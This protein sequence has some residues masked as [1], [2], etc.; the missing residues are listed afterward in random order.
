[1]P[2]KFIR[3]F[4]TAFLSIITCYGGLLAQNIA[5]FEENKGQWPAQ[6]QFR[7]D[8][9]GGALFLEKSGMTWHLVDQ[10]ADGHH[11]HA[12]ESMKGHVLRMHLEGAAQ[13]PAMLA[14]ENLDGYSNYFKGKNRRNW[15]GNIAAFGNITQQDVYPGIDWKIYSNKRG[16]KYDFIVKPGADPAQIRIH[17]AGAEKIELRS[18]ALIIH[19]SLGEITE[20]APIA[21]QIIDGIKKPITCRFKIDKGEIILQTGKYNPGE[22]L[23][24]DPQLVFGSFSGSAADNWGFTATYDHAGNTYSAGIVFGIGYPTITGAYQQNFAGGHGSRPVD[25]GII[26]Y[27][28]AGKRLYTTYLGGSGNELPQSLVVS[29]NNELFLFGTT[30]S[31]DFPTTSTAYNRAFAGGE[32]VSILNNGIRFENG[33]DMFICRLSETGNSLLA[34]TLIGGSKNDGLN[35][36][37]QLKYNYAD[38]GRGAIIIDNLN[39]VYIGCSTSSLDFPVPGNAFQPAYGGGMQD[40]VVIK[41]DMNLTR[42]FWGSYL[43]GSGAD[44]IF[45][46][47]L[48]KPGNVFVTG[49]TTSSNFPAQQGCYQSTAGGGKADGFI[50]G[51]RPNGQT[52]FASTYYGSDAY[53][54]PYLIATN[55][56]NEVY[57]YGQTEKSGNFYLQNF[58]W[59]EN[60]GKQF[61]SK[62]NNLL[63]Q[64]LWS[65]TFG[66]GKN[67]PDI[68]PSAFT[69]DICGQVFVCGWGGASNSSPEGGQFSG[70][71]GMTTTPDAYQTTTD[72]SDFYLMVLHE[73]DQSLVYASFFGG[74]GSSE[75]VDGG[76][77]RFDRR[78]VVYQSVCAGCGGRDDFP[79]TP[80]VWSNVNGSNSGCNNAIFK[81]DFQLPAT[82]ASFTSPPVGCAPFATSFSNSSSNALS[83]SWKVNGQVISTAENPDYTF[84]QPGLYLVELVASNPSSCNQQDTFRKQVRVVSST[85]DIFDT[86]SICYLESR[87]IGP[88]FPVDPYYEVSWTP[89][90]GLDDPGAQAPL[91][92]PE[93]STAYRLL[94][95]LGSCTDTLDQFIHVNFDS[96]Y[97]G[98]DL[99]I[100]R[101]QQINIG[102]PGDPEN[103]HYKWSPANPLN[104][105][106]TTMPLAT[107]DASTWFSL[108]RTPKD[109]NAGCPGRDSLLLAIPE[110]AP[111]AAFET[112]MIASCTEV[113]VLLINKSE[114]AT[115][116]NWDFG[117]S[118]SNAENP[119][120]VYQYGDSVQI[121][122]IVHNAVCSDTIDFMQPLKD[123]D[124]FFKIHEVNAF[125][126]N[127]DGQN[128]CFS[129]A[130]QDLPAPDDKNFIRCTTLRIFD[131]W[132]KLV[133]ESVET[134][135]GCWDGMNSQG[136]EMP[137]GSYVFL[138]E[139]QGQKLEGVVS[140]LR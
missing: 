55:R 126:P 26:K 10:A 73:T 57:V 93:L 127:G 113:K 59:K 105:A 24:I 123:L 8:I 87:K 49:G 16:L 107:V 21:W 112:E 15:A 42:L 125:S 94:L 69:V 80:G 122:L 37:S 76:T 100:C 61:I 18:G 131:R 36:A 96:L 4:K 44:G 90:S 38:D 58:G 89:A 114:Q 2:G 6:V 115:A 17:Y 138:F 39:N 84:Q 82:V 137:E 136:Q 78:G 128:D 109:Q 121:R 64:R 51:I 85:Y 130:L 102:L 101:G 34:S 110:G 19:T 70:T 52:L 32:T 133:F 79:T 74:P 33:T 53:D 41:M 81:F 68:S 92:A 22:T 66:T 28:K 65:T 27:D 1:M 106:D 25:I 60:N 129:P 75:H 71:S 56:Q 45:S 43:G 98:P 30:G 91:A 103:Y 67:K 46:L 63:E 88:L 20:E 97:A 83:Y 104:N 35:V 99:N 124:T 118:Q 117:H 132:G 3:L 62:F 23:I 134:E 31:A 13:S 12:M 119:Q 111:L 140:L 108:L 14:Q 9:P 7:A 50:S 47:T 40:G 116:Y 54:Q 120:V 11:H 77:S 29:S 95:Q 5:R 139:G 48:D 86:L 135:N 72:N